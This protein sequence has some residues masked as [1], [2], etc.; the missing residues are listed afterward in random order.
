MSSYNH[1]AYGSVCDWLY[2]TAAGIK[3]LETAAGFKEVV[4][5]PVP[6]KR[7]GGISASLDTAY[8]TIKSSWRYD[9]DTVRYEIETPVNAAVIINNE[10]YFISRGTYRFSD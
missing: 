5:A 7:L 1:Y 10:K 3:P 2:S 8:G 4:I 6:D 9:G